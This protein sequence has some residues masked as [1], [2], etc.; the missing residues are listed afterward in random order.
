M[1]LR[2]RV[3]AVAVWSREA[4][5]GVEERPICAKGRSAAMFENRVMDM[6]VRLGHASAVEYLESVLR[7]LCV[8]PHSAIGNS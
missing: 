5:Q 2:R 8:I 6:P 7:L 3:S 4:L 1:H